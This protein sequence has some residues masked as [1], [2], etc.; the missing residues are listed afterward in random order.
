MNTQ[1][2]RQDH[3]TKLNSLTFCEDWSILLVFLRL[4]E[5]SSIRGVKVLNSRTHVL[6]FCRQSSYFV[7]SE[8]ILGGRHESSWAPDLYDFVRIV[9]VVAK[10]RLHLRASLE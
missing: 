9:D 1:A 7:R 2:R 3:N 8:Q 10:G 5:K 6:I 4:E